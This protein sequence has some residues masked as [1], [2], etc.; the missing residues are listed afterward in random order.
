MTQISRFRNF[1]KLKGLQG[2]S[3]TNT[4]LAEA[5]AAAS[6]SG[7]TGLEPPEEI[8][9]PPSKKGLGRIGRK[10]AWHVS[11][12]WYITKRDKPRE[13]SCVMVVLE[14]DDSADIRGMIDRID[15][16]D[17]TDDG[18]EDTLH[19]TIKY[20][21]HGSDAGP[22]RKLVEKYGPIKLRL[23][24]TSLFESDK[25]DV[26]KID[27]ESDDLRKLNRLLSDSLPNTETHPRYQPHLTLA[28]VKSG[29]GKKYAGW[30]DVE[31]MELEFNGVVFSSPS[32]NKTLLETASYAYAEKRRKQWDSMEDGGKFPSTPEEEE[33]AGGVDKDVD[34]AAKPT[35]QEPPAKKKP[36]SRLKGK[37]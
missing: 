3:W 30:V 24:K 1:L 14:K 5:I 6:S 7:P 35:D 23:G 34:D 37:R 26:V 31:G 18:K 11:L 2:E 25:Y 19:V 16:A 22:V 21:I 10:K 20:G 32:S 36:K 12:P 9:G 15:D 13:F 33:I 29:A 4:Q 27:V 28:Y 17:L 8:N